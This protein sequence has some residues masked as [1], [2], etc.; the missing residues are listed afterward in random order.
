MSSRRG[1]WAGPGGTPAL[2]PAPQAPEP[3]CPANSR[4]GSLPAEAGAGVGGSAPAVPCY[5]LPASAQS[6]RQEAGTERGPSAGLVSPAAILCCPPPGGLERAPPGPGRARGARGALQ[7]RG[8]TKVMG[9]GCPAGPSWAVAFLPSPTLACVSCGHPLFR[10]GPPARARRG[11]SWAVPQPTPMG[12]VF[13]STM[14]LCGLWPPAGPA[15][16][17]TWGEAPRGC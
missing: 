17:Q 16:G 9:A 2:E 6:G 13:L 4:V 3:T 1:W 15:L 8:R 14:H 10:P 12:C 11:A 7:A 5:L